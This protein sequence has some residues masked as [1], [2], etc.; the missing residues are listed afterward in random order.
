MEVPQL[1]LIWSQHNNI[2]HTPDDSG[3]G[4]GRMMAL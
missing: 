3:G 1:A 4:G 2:D